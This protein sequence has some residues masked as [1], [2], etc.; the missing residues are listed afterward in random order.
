MP[1]ELFRRFK[2]GQ[3]YAPL[4]ERLMLTALTRF[5]GVRFPHGAPLIRESNQVLGL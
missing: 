5:M 3:T 2:S 4:A 1:A